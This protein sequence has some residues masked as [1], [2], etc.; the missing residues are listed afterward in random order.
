[1]N[2]RYAFTLIELLV[3]IAII[4]ILSAVLYPVFSGV[5]QRSKRAT[6][7]SNLR[8]C[9]VALRLYMDD[10]ATNVPPDSK[11]ASELLKKMP[12]CCLNDS[13]WTKGCTQ[14]FGPPM[15]GSYAYVRALLDI[16][17]PT[18]EMLAKYYDAGHDYVWMVDIF[19]STYGIPAPYYAGKENQRQY[20]TRICQTEPLDSWK[21]TAFPNNLLGL[22]DDGHVQILNPEGFAPSTPHGGFTFSWHLIFQIPNVNSELAPVSR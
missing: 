15:V 8:Q 11:T 5:R 3:V 6:C 1:M 21:R 9:G 7:I 18:Y 20:T 10:Y 16:D 13:E 12:T 14:P 2:R 19:H 4:G 22:S 17:H